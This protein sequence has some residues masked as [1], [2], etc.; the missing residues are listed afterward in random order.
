MRQIS[1]R[2]KSAICC[3]ASASRRRWP[4]TT[5]HTSERPRP[6]GAPRRDREG[7]GANILLY[8]APGT[9][10][11]EFVKTLGAHLRPSISSAR[12]KANAEPK[13]QERIAALTIANAIGATTENMIVAV[14]EADD[15]FA[16]VD[17]D[18]AST[19]QGRRCS[20]TGSSSASRAPTIWI[21][22][23]CRSPRTGRG[24]AHEPR[25]A[26][27]AANRGRPPQDCGADRPPEK[28]DL[29]AHRRR[30][31]RRAFR[32]RPPSSRT[33]SAPPPASA[34]RAKRRLRFSAAV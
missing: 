17:E 33:P 28:V 7:P 3:S 20:C 31:P 5:S 18:N 4:G 14:D 15:L 34:A 26:V 27:S 22:N 13:R 30:P 9:G 19:R 16:G 23:D 12:D 29:D 8:G 1:A 2:R 25:R 21:V 32:P 24:A 6:R 11:S 10:K